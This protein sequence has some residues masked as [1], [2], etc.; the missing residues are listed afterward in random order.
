MHN[1]GV[2][3]PFD[4]TQ[5]SPLAALEISHC[6][7]LVVK[8]EFYTIFSCQ[9]DVKANQCILKEPVYGTQFDLNKLHSDLER[10]I[11]GEDN[12]ILEFN[13]CEKSLTKVCA[14]AKSAAC[15][16]KNGK[17]Y[18]FGMRNY[19]RFLSHS[20]LLWP[21]I[22]LKNRYGFWNRT[23]LH[24]RS[25]LFQFHRRYLQQKHQRTIQFG[26]S[27]I[28]WLLNPHKGANCCNALRKLYSIIYSAFGFQLINALK[29]FPF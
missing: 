5:L 12:D 10:K 2:A 14:G 8:F 17:Q 22:R 19:Y 13:V 15:L 23:R 26:H 18:K 11:G 7:Q 4:V 3:P 24:K 6:I 1:L 27:H 21:F 16:T 29:K 20:Q 9:A 25:Y 28:L